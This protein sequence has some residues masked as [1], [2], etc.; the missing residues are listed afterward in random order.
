MKPN[1]SAWQS[2]SARTVAILWLLI[3]S[4]MTAIHGAELS[5]LM[6]Q[7]QNTESEMTFDEI[8]ARLSTLENTLTAIQAQPATA[9]REEL[10]KAL[11]P[12][13]QRLAVLAQQQTHYASTDAVTTLTQ[14]TNQLSARLDKLA[15][16]PPS[17]STPA[18]IPEPKKQSPRRLPPFH[19]VAT[20]QRGD[21]R[22]LSVMPQNA[23]E[24]S[25]LRLLRPGDSVS[26]WTLISFD[27]NNALFRIGS[28]KQRLAI[29][30][31][32]P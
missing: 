30:R 6:D 21:E 2:F 31:S 5:Q 8:D 12:I 15:S 29:P 13:T 3:I 4:V 11:V 28:Q 26:G 14:Y 23:T 27:Y 1:L 19:I 32:A 9:S 7:T 20:E 25:Q 17:V 22:F 24:V 10:H 16:T 18:K